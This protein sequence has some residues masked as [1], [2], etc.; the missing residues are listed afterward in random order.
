METIAPHEFEIVDLAETVLS[1]ES[2]S[3]QAYLA[4]RRAL[5][6]GQFAPGA[7]LILRTVAAS[8]GISSTPVREALLKLASENALTLDV[9]GTVR[10]PEMTRDKYIEIRDLRV[11]LEGEAAARAAVAI[12]GIRAG[13]AG[14][15]S[16]GTR[17]GPGA[18]E[19]SL[20]A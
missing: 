11:L 20:R 7:K 13:R 14:A 5:M 9:R 4:I 15:D 17:T 18:E 19:L 8:L 2:I 3:Q 12:E 1:R 16:D 10:V 6:G